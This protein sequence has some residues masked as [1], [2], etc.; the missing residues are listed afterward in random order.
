LVVVVA[1][2]GER[3]QVTLVTSYPEFASHHDLVL[4]A[5]IKRLLLRYGYPPDKEE[6]ATQ[7]ILGQAEVIAGQPDA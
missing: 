5:T 7:L 1:V 2:N 4:R 6:A 3:S